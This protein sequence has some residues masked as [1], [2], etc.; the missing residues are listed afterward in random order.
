MHHTLRYWKSICSSETASKLST[1]TIHSEI[2]NK[3]ITENSEND[4]KHEIDENEY[5]IDDL[6]RF[7]FFQS[8]EFA[9]VN[10]F[11]SATS[12]GPL[13]GEPLRSTAFFID[14]FQVNVDQEEENTTFFKGLL[15]SALTNGFKAAFEKGSTRLVEPFYHCNVNVSGSL[16]V[17]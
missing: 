2:D 15:T 9:I 1:E 10:A 7:T 4:H 8:I 3:N 13:C 16:I 11:Q 5:T 12:A 6:K 14:Q 17:I